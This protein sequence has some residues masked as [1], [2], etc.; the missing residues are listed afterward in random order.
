MLLLLLRPV[1]KTTVH[2]YY[3]CTAYMV[4]ETGVTTPKTTTQCS[5]STK[6]WAPVA[7]GGARGAAIQFN[8]MSETLAT[9]YKRNSN[10]KL[11]QWRIWAEGGAYYTEEGL[12]N[13]KITRSKPHTCEGKNPG[14]ANATTP[15]AQAVKEA[16]AKWEKKLA[17]GYTRDIKAVD[18][19]AFKKPMK[20][21][22][23]R[24][25]EDEIVYPVQVQD[26]LNGVRCQNESKGALST[27]GKLFHT[28]PHIRAALAPIFDNYPDAFIDGEAYNHAMKHRLNRLVEIVSVVYQPKDITP[29]MLAESQELVKFYIFDGYGFA[30]ITKETPWVE[31]YAAVSRLVSR[32]Q[33]E[34]KVGRHL[35]MHPYWVAKD[36]AEVKAALAKNREEGGEGLMIRWGKCEYK[37]GRSKYMLKDKHFDDDEFEIVAIE[38]GNGDWVG[39][40]KR[41]VLKLHKPTP[42]GETTFASNIEGDR[43]WLREL[44]ERREEFIGEMATVEYQQL[45]EYGVPQIPFVRA[46]RNYE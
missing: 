15:E 27:G 46:I 4:S 30:G 20:G 37:H 8:D 5:N 13:G 3:N 43:D 23:F 18:S 42:T 29:E 33:E 6:R 9:L 2:P 32:I 31:R 24:D 11:Q 26:K 39:C 35:V 16:K 41:I 10:G 25:R 45:S 44:Y 28:I 34:F 7:N 12:V 40:A 19:V 22:K 17:T 38:E 36:K 14:K 1:I 21:D